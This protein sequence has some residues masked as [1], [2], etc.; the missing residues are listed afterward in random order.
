[1]SSNRQDIDS[2]CSSS[3]IFCQI[4]MQHYLDPE[5]T[6]H[7]LPCPKNPNYC[8][9]HVLPPNPQTP[10]SLPGNQENKRTPSS[11]FLMPQEK[12]QSWGKP[13]LGTPK[14]RNTEK[15]MPHTTKDFSSS[16]NLKIQTDK[17]FL[18]SGGMLLQIFVPSKQMEPKPY[19]RVSLHDKEVSTSSTSCVVGVF[20]SSL[21]KKVN[22]IKVRQCYFDIH[23]Q[24]Q[25]S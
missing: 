6:V 12:S 1:M 25:D 8:H 11:T 2:S 9:L 24:Y 16:F 13:Y 21:S 20:V 17:A 5:L 19:C 15:Y 23:R 3:T 7:L 14:G 22:E 18:I 10:N 4:F